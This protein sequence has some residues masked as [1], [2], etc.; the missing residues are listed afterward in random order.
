MVLAK[1]S[2][3]SI[4][5]P[6]VIPTPKFSK[7][8]FYPQGCINYDQVSFT[9]DPLHSSIASAVNKKRS[10][11]MGWK[12]TSRFDLR[13]PFPSKCRY[14]QQELFSTALQNWCFV[15]G[16]GRLAILINPGVV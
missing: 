12:W 10:A 1:Q 8:I 14:P 16:G 15:D 6:F 11:A 2:F 5:D 3:F 13:I 4:A 9:S 7:G